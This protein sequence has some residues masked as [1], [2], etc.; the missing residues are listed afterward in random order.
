M[1]RNDR[2]SPKKQFHL[3]H[4][5]PV[6]S[7]DDPAAVPWRRPP[8]RVDGQRGRVEPQGFLVGEDGQGFTAGAGYHG[9]VVIAVG[10]AW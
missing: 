3:R 2:F 7:D 10:A 4:V 9:V 8:G 6:H 1:E 5:T